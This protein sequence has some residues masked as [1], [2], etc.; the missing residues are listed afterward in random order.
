MHKAVGW[1]LRE[2][3]KRSKEVEV[4]F[5]EVHAHHMPR[6][7]LRYAI[8]RFLEKSGSIF[9]KE[10]GCKKCGRDKE[11]RPYGRLLVLVLGHRSSHYEQDRL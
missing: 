9:S 1:M 4:V 11:A 2:V 3:G 6:T 5:F 8:E 7:T 10:R